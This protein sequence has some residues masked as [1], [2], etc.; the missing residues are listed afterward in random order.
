MTKFLKNSEHPE[1]CAKRLD[2]LSEE[3]RQEGSRFNKGA[4][5][6][7]GTVVAAH[8]PTGILITD[9]RGSRS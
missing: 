3:P 4:R 1:S 5:K 7:S 9:L 6:G 8:S 2:V